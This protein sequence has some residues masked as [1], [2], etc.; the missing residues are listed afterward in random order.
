MPSGSAVRAARVGDLAAVAGIYAHWVAVSTATFDEV[1]PSPADWRERFDDLRR[2]G[3]PFLVVDADGAVCGYALCAPWKPRAGYRHT[4]EDSVYVA[5]DAVGRG[6]GGTLLGA[7]VERCRDAGLRQVIAVVAWPGGEAALA[8]HERH[9]FRH[10]GLL[11]AVGDKHG[12]RLDT[13][14]LQRDLE[15]PAAATGPGGRSG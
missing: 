3:L 11:R 9:G 13:L 5:P 2:R 4:V 15:T 1:A 7:L 8:V 14:L 12:R 10:A 6:V